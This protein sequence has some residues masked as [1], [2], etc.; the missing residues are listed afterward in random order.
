MGPHATENDSLRHWIHW[1]TTDNPRSL[2][3]PN[4]AIR[5]QAE[6]DDHGEAFPR[7]HEGPDLWIYIDAW[8]QVN[9]FALYFYNKDGHKG[10]NRNRDY[11][12]EIYLHSSPPAMPD[13]STRGPLLSNGKLLPS[14][15]RTPDGS[16]APNTYKKFFRLNGL[17]ITAQR[18]PIAQARVRDFWGGVYK[19]F[20]LTGP[21]KYW[22]R[23]QK[24]TS[25]NTIVSGC[26]LDP[27]TGPRPKWDIKGLTHG[28]AS[29][30]YFAPP[31]PESLPT[32]NSCYSAFCL[33]QAF[34]NSQMSQGIA[35]LILPA[36]RFA[37]RAADGAMPETPLAFLGAMKWYLGVWEETDRVRFRDD[38]KMFWWATQKGAAILRTRHYRPFSPNV[39]DTAKEWENRH[40]KEY[41]LKPY[42][43]RGGYSE[44]FSDKR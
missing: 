20:V 8:A 18:E 31:L 35:S 37:Y 38:M 29:V 21:C 42:P 2:Y 23:I 30:P 28:T 22:V 27:L 13:G 19:Q 39:Y 4:Q 14:D 32:T 15:L 33:W 26:F 43:F 9:R 12:I 17:P 24:G 11:R 40:G 25:L 44:C 10:E 36:R 6:W 7:T 16:L 5:R 3:V 1:I 34:E 41:V